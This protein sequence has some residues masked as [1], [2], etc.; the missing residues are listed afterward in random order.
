MGG[1]NGRVETGRGE[2]KM[3]KSRCNKIR[4]EARRRRMKRIGWRCEEI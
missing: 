1:E 4:G 3:S 2:K